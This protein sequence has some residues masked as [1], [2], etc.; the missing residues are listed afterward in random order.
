M[1][2]RFFT[3]AGLLSLSGCAP[4]LS[5]R[6]F[7]PEWPDTGD[8]LA[9]NPCSIRKEPEVIVQGSEEERSYAAKTVSGFSLF[10]KNQS[11][12]QIQQQAKDAAAGQL[13]RLR[14]VNPIFLCGLER[15]EF[16]GQ[17]AYESSFETDQRDKGVAHYSHSERTL[18][19]RMY[20]APWPIVHEVGHHIHNL[21]YFAP[22]IR[23]F[24]SQSWEYK[25]GERRHRCEGSHCFIYADAGTSPAEDWARH[26]ENVVLKPDETLLKT[27]L[28]LEVAGRTA[29]QNKIRLIFDLRTGEKPV[30]GTLDVGS[31]L[32]LPSSAA[33]V[34]SSTGISLLDPGK[35]SITYYE[36]K[37]GQLSVTDGNTKDTAVWARVLL[38]QQYADLTEISFFTSQ[39]RDRLFVMA[40]TD[41]FHPRSDRKGTAIYELSPAGAASN[42]AFTKKHATS[43]ETILSGFSRIGDSIGYF[44]YDQGDVILRELES[45]AKTEINRWKMPEK[46]RPL[47][48]MP[49]GDG[50][51]LLV[52]A[53]E[54]ADNY[55]R[56][57]LTMLRISRTG[58]AQESGFSVSRE[59][60]IE[61]EN[62]LIRNFRPPVRYGNSIIFPTYLSYGT[63]LGLLIYDLQQN[64]F[65]IPMFVTQAL[66]DAFKK[67]SNRL[68]NVQISVSDGQL[69]VIASVRK[70]PTLVAP[71]TLKW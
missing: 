20:S 61:L 35:K 17:K 29:L 53:H 36:F 59:G 19:I 8:I 26:F 7:Y 70:G 12:A 28:N 25:D 30:W 18:R 11:N 66:P 57:K 13:S 32:E 31:A 65:S 62:D 4:S 44:S 67:A 51:G 55:Y 64:R 1:N 14:S 21:G 56:V 41:N 9:T 60:S 46:I 40:R 54:E 16:L 42:D 69:Y 43:Q 48:V 33:Q 27:N 10:F 22:T 63:T 50:N 15:V 68:Q 39:L 2:A 49:L 71:I 6:D 24:L 34:P 47:H 45:P 23:D 3:F 38:S 52:L 37:K 58:G 5:N